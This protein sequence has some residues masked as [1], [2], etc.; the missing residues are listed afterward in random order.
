MRL[1]C[2]SFWS[3]ARSSR[4]QAFYLD[5]LTIDRS[6]ELVKVF[7]HE[8][9]LHIQ[10]RWSPQAGWLTTPFCLRVV[11]LTNVGSFILAL[12]GILILAATRAANVLPTPLVLP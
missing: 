9:C 12:L 4:L 11:H 6:T 3:S 10:H 5:R 2:Q 1:P 8:T 7:D